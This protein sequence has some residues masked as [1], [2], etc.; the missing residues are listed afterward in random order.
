MTRRGIPASPMARLQFV[1][2]VLDAPLPE[3]C[4]ATCWTGTVRP[5]ALSCAS[6]VRMGQV[7]ISSI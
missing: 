6:A 2:E 4:R 5:P 3:V 7:S 1:A